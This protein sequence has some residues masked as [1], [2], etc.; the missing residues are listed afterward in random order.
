MESDQEHDADPHALS[1]ELA[2]LDEQVDELKARM[3][4]VAAARLADEVRRRARAG[5]LL[6]HYLHAT[7]SRMILAG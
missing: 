4:S 3:H 2:R 5:R 7:F 6:Y 1:E